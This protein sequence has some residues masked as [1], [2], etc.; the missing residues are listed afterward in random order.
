MLS[1]VMVQTGPPGELSSILPP[2]VCPG[3]TSFYEQYGV[4][5]DVLQNHLTEALMFLIMELPANVS[6]AQEV[7]QHKLQALQSLWGLERSSA[8]LGQYQAYDRQV[9]EELQE[10]PG[11][12]STT[13]TFAG[14]GLGWALAR[15][16][17]RAEGSRRCEQYRLHQLTAHSG[18]CS[19]HYW[20]GNWELDKVI[21]FSCQLTKDPGM[22]SVRTKA[23]LY[24]TSAL[25]LEVACKLLCLFMKLTCSLQLGGEALFSV[26]SE[27]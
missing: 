12:V 6:S 7:L 8:V 3:R 5:R 27:P 21:L 22:G 14:E 15:G 17:G 23:H 10:A 24:K 26:M 2:P 25:F 16:A 1:Q 18:M 11:Y 19:R 9:Q 20:H 13:P 4:I